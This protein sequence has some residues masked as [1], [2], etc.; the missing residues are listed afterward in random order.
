LARDRV[1]ADLRYI[2]EHLPNVHVVY[3]DPNFAVRFDEMMGIIEEV[4]AP[5]RSPYLMES[6]LSVLTPQRLSR[7]RT[8]HC[9]YVAPGVESWANYSSKAGVGDRTGREKLELVVDHFAQL[10]EFVPSLQGQFH[11]RHRRG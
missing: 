10:R 9:V 4:P 8:T 5:R 2:A 3:H 6:S 7:L 1:V 11:L